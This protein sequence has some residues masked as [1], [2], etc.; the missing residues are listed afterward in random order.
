MLLVVATLM[1]ID[2]DV[3]RFNSG[4]IDNTLEGKLTVPVLRQRQQHALVP[5]SQMLTICHVPLGVTCDHLASTNSCTVLPL[6]SIGYRQK[7]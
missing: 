2:H 7:P 5:G 1:K 4:A 6:T 3:V